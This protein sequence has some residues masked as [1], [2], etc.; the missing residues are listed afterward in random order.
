ML[1]DFTW[2]EKYEEAMSNEHPQV[3]SYAILCGVS[4]A[5]LYRIFASAI[6]S[7][8]YY[9]NIEQNLSC[10]ILSGASWTTLHKAFPCGMLSQDNTEQDFFLSSIVGSLKD[11]IV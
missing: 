6:L 10:A 11:N 4:W 5:T 3:F 2:T 1:R 9:G 7:Q 8:K